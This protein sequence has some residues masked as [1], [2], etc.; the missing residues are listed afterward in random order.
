MFSRACLGTI[1][2]LE[3]FFGQFEWDIRRKEH[4]SSG[5]GDKGATDSANRNQENQSS[6]VVLY[7]LYCPSGSLDVFYQK[8]SECTAP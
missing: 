1:R 8:N 5:P 7:T 6:G 4:A 3:Q 2:A